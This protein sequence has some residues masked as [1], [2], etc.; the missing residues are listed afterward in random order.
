MD[1]RSA[2]ASLLQASLDAAR[3]TPD[4]MTQ[5][6]ESEL[7]FEIWQDVYLGTEH[8]AASQSLMEELSI[9]LVINITSGE[10]KVP[11]FFAPSVSYVNYELIDQPGEDILTEAIRDGTRLISAWISESD[12]RTAVLVHCS[13]GL[14][15][16]ATV[17]IAWLMSS[18]SMNLREAVEHV[19]LRRGRTLRV[20]PSFWMVILC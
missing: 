3:H 2:A 16:S 17:L 5:A 12:H 11:N 13:A 7:V 10:H 9:G 1:I 15:R 20:N 18:Q 6:S 8:G 14:S 19:T 4:D